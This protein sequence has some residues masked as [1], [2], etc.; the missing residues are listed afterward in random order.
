MQRILRTIKSL[1]TSDSGATAI[2]YG[3]IASLVSI[4]IAAVIF[5]MGD[6]LRTL[7]YEDLLNFFAAVLS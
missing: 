4:S 7:F 6:S 2:E 1:F 5:L 3:L